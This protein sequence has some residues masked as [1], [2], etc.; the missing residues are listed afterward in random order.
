VNETATPR[1]RGEESNPPCPFCGAKTN[2]VSSPAP[3]KNREQGGVY[4]KRRHYQCTGSDRHPVTTDEILS[5]GKP[6]LV[7]KRDRSIVPFDFGKLVDSMRM[8]GS[9]NYDETV[10]AKLAQ[11]I[12]S[13]AFKATTTRPDVK[14]ALIDSSA[15]GQLALFVLRKHQRMAMWIRYSLIFE[16]LD[17]KKDFSEVVQ[18]LKNAWERVT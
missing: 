5:D 15:V 1:I 13:L 11:E 12:T 4:R 10:Y 2:L 18:A 8:A 17:Q 7:Q 3:A 6:M 16:G 14:G 9:P